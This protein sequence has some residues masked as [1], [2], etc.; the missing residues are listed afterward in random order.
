MIMKLSNN[1][2]N[3]KFNKKR[4]KKRNKIMKPYKHLTPGENRQCKDVTNIK[5]VKII[6]FSKKRR[7]KK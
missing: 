3:E 6:N 7:K 2:K 4:S 5:K 1:R